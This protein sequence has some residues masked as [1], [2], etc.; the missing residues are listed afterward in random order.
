MLG[1]PAA[2]AHESNNTLFNQHKYTLGSADIALPRTINNKKILLLF[3]KKLL[4][5]PEFEPTNFQNTSSLQNLAN[6]NLS[7]DFALIGR[8]YSEHNGDLAEV[9]KTAAVA[10]LNIIQSFHT[11]WSWHASASLSAPILPVLP[12][13][14]Y[15][16]IASFFKSDT[17]VNG[18][19]QIVIVTVVSPSSYSAK[20]ILRPTKYSL[21]QKIGSLLGPRKSFFVP[22]E[23][24]LQDGLCCCLKYVADI[25]WKTRKN[26]WGASDSDKVVQA[27]QKMKTTSV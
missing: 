9:T 2:N 25:G 5:A 19:W 20:V 27:G 11:I 10:I 15:F 1:S 8:H 4:P 12:T 23:N 13:S 3:F 14:S 7:D 22:E 18:A 24:L 26:S 16:N 17:G 21:L 6:L